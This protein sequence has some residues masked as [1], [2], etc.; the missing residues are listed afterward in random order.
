MKSVDQLSYPQELIIESVSRTDKGMYQ[1]VADASLGLTGDSPSPAAATSKMTSGHGGG[2][3][4]AAWPR[5]RRT[6]R[7]EAVLELGGNT[8]D[9][10]REWK[11]LV[12]L[13]TSQLS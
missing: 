13:A 11:L 2:G 10:Q 3:E 6:A 1:C 9:W 7:G 8:R 12:I 5:R 4:R